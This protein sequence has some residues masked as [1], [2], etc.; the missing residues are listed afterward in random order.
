[1]RLSEICW[2]S[3]IASARSSAVEAALE[4]GINVDLINKTGELEWKP[5][6]NHVGFE[7]LAIALEGIS[8]YMEHV[9]SDKTEVT[10]VFTPPA[11]PSLLENVLLTHGYVGSMVDHT[12]AIFKHIAGLA[13]ERLIVM[14]P[15]IDDIGMTNLI[16]TFECT[17]KDVERILITRLVASNPNRAILDNQPQLNSMSVKIYSYWLPKGDRYETFHA[18]L[19]IADCD[20]AYVGS[21]N[22]TKASLEVSME[23][24]VML[25]GKGAKTLSEIADAVLQIA[26]LIP[27]S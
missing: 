10:V 5:N 21:A 4:A 20:L 2:A 9:H 6:D 16:S 19:L 8:I 3:G 26:P 11:K 23:L 7:Q 14:M 18:K 27:L 17:K 25:K 13:K 24:G 15:F 12:D 22:A 1:M